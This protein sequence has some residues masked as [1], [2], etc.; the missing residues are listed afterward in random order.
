MLALVGPEGW[1]VDPSATLD[2]WHDRG[3]AE[4][5]LTTEEAALLLHVTDVPWP[6][7]AELHTSVPFLVV[8]GGCGCGCASFDVR[9][10]RFPEH[11]HELEHWCNAVSSDNSSGVA[12]WLGSE[13]R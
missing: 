5:A 6:R 11:R 10:T 13:G 2:R 1:A 8:T 4:R 12:V 7:A 9:D 3:M